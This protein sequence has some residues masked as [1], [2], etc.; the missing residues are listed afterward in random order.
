MDL[1]QFQ[2]SALETDNTARHYEGEE[3]RKDIVVALLGIAGELGTL[4][5]AYKKFLRDG[6]SY[7][8]YEENVQEELG[9]MLWYLAVLADKFGLSLSSIA[10]ANLRKTSGRWG[11][12]A[13]IAH[14]PYDAAFPLHERLPRKFDIRFSERDID[15]KRKVVIELDGSPI[16]NSLTDNNAFEDGYRFHDAFHLA[17]AA[18]LGWS[19]VTRK[20][21]GKKRRSDST[22]DETEDG[23]RAIVIEE[24]IAAYV[25][26]YGE[27]HDGLID[28]RA[29][30]FEVLK[31]AKS[32]TH[33]LE[34]SSKSWNDWENAIMA[35][36][37]IFRQLKEHNG[38][39][40]KCDLDQ[41]TIE[42]AAN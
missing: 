39:L 9:D 17:F 19:P 4:A 25:F 10:N 27:A 40:I 16:G 30:D 33:R 1:D 35:G 41:Q 7:G 13:A 34:V 21:M 15:G 42:F 23:G 37:R 3:G 32:M 29:V 24:G 5:T 14:P 38:G 2:R 26:D 31:T 28:V 36:W 20:L 11:T 8:L 12:Q 18:V 22:V 6:P